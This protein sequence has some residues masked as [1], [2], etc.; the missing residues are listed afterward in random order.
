MINSEVTIDNTRYVH[1]SVKN[2][3]VLGL[4]LELGKMKY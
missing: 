4:H 1:S 2:E 3:I